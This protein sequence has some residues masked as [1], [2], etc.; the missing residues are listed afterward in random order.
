MNEVNAQSMENWKR[1]FFTIWTGQAVSLVGS[2]LVQF[3][4]IWYLTR[5]TGSAIVLTTAT[6]VGMLPQVFIGPIAGSIVD[7]GNRRR[8]MILSDSAIALVTLALALLFA[9][10]LAEIWHIY[11]M[12]FL[13]SLGGAFHGPSFMASTSLM[14]PKQHLARI[15][16]FNQT[17]QGGL[18]IFS[19]PVGAFLLGIMPMQGILAIDVVTALLAVVSLL[20]V[21]IPQPER[22]P[23]P[24][25]Q[26]PATIWQDIKK[27]MRYVLDWRGLTIILV[28]A[29]LLNFLLTPAFSLL[30]LVVTN[31]FNAGAIELGWLEAGFGVGVVLGG[32]LLGLWGG[33]KR[34]IVTAISGLIGLGLGVVLLGLVPSTGLGIAIGAMFLAGV[35]QPITNGSLGAIL[36]AAVDPGM[37]GRVFTLTTTVATAISPLGL[38]IAGPLSEVLGIQTWYLVGGAMCVLMGLYAFSSRPVMTIEEGRTGEPALEGG[39]G[40]GAPEVGLRDE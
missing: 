14:V 39:A 7:R 23:L 36:Q 5:E 12:L 26:A 15:Q 40:A 19:A 3:A 28:M 8:I 20:L 21:A 9:L 4:L 18:N 27:G 2:Q 38:L 37:Q 31:H 17:L 34:R 29:T 25:G 24:D 11:A 30:P 1:P 16:G 10:G 32:L 6:L 35:M 22:E 13:R 33:F